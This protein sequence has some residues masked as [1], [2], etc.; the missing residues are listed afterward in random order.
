[1]ENEEL[2]K[3]LKFLARSS[4]IVLIGLIFSSLLSYVFRVIIARHFGPDTYGLFSISFMV[5]G[6]F[7]IFSLVGLGEGVI[8]Y[9][10]FYRGKNDFL[11]IKKIF[12]FALLLT[13]LLSLFFGVIMYLSAGEL[14]T[15]IF[16]NNNLTLFLQIFSITVPLFA[17]SQILLGTMKAFEKVS[18][19]SFL[20]NIFNP[21]IRVIALVTL[22]FLGFNSSSIGFS[23]VIGYLLLLISSYYLCRKYAIKYFTNLTNKS[24][25]YEGISKELLSYSIPLM[26]AAFVSSLLGWVDIFS[27]GYLKNASNVGV[28]DSALPIATTLTLASFLFVQLFFPIINKEYSKNNHNLIKD[29]SKQVG[30]WIFILNLPLLFFTI[31]F[32]KA[33]LNILFGAKFISGGYALSIL[34]IGFFF[35]AQSEIGLNLLGMIKKSKIRFVNIL[36]ALVIDA[37]LNFILIPKPVIF[38]LDNSEGIIGAAIATTIGYTIYSILTFAQ[39]YHYL[40]FLPLKRKMFGVLF[41]A[42]V[43]GG[44]LLYL[45]N[46]IPINFFSLVLL[47]LLFL[48]IYFVMI[49]LTKS[50]DKNDLLILRTIKNKMSNSFINRTNN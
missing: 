44:V 50:L 4:I 2:N 13:V 11:K 22:I 30:K 20:I 46:L 34:S 3:N 9:I 17:I 39:T 40:G 8:R 28:Y 23:V 35:Y 10:S 33:M 42:F 47:G 6:W 19:Y 38:S 26:F 36:I 18:E 7:V 27:L 48:L 1:M 5:S 14:A 25:D 32:P 16:H 12:T 49:L 37:V 21:L 43:A 15:R 24:S 45:R 31:F 29:L 41:S